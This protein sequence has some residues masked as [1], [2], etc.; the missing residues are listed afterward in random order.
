[1]KRLAGGGSRV[2]LLHGCSDRPLV[3]FQRVWEACVRVRKP[4]RI[5]LGIVQVCATGSISAFCTIVVL[6]HA[7]ENYL[8]ARLFMRWVIDTRAERFER[9]PNAAVSM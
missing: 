2:C 6:V 8:L 9:L 7:T 3:C 5:S 4:A 1:M